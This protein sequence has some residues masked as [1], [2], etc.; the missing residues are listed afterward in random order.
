MSATAHPDTALFASSLFDGIPDGHRALVWTA[1]DKR[2]HWCDGPDAISDAAVA[3]AG[4]ADVYI[5]AGLRR[6]GHGPHVRGAYEDITG[7]VG[8]WADLDYAH[9]VHK[10]KVLPPD[11]D[12]VLGLLAEL[13]LAPTFIVHSGH[14]LQAWWG[15]AEPYMFE[16]AADR[17]RT[18]ALV[19]GWHQRITA[20]GRAHGWAID[21]VWDLPRILRLPG[22]FNRKS[23][24]YRP[25]ELVGPFGPVYAGPSDFADH[26]VPVPVP[27]RPRAA[28]GGRTFSD[29][30]TVAGITYDP[31]AEPPADRLTALATNDKKFQGSWDR[32]RRDFTDRSP[33]AYDQSLASIAA[34]AGWSD[35]EIVNLLIAARRKHGDDLKRPDYYQRT[36]ERARSGTAE[37]D[38]VATADLADLATED[39]DKQ[40]AIL[41]AVFGARLTRVIRRGARNAGLVYVLEFAGA[42]EDSPP[43]AVTLQAEGVRSI[44][45]LRAV[46]DAIFAN[47]DRVMSDYAR[48]RWRGLVQVIANCAEEDLF[49][50]AQRAAEVWEWVRSYVKERDKGESVASV[51]AAFLGDEP[52]VYDGRVSIHILHLRSYIVTAFHDIVPA[53]ELRLRLRESGFTGGP[54]TMRIDDRVV[55]RYRWTADA[56][57]LETE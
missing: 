35:Q 33:S 12:A 13:P 10:G 43:I 45:S 54:V 37:A 26:V 22:T 36:I 48:A 40:L 6:A 25:V 53:A 46:Q 24:P 16:D 31:A 23:A 3:L 7:I 42:D 20:A 32:T 5:G 52:Y 11:V 17:A 27:E 4:A 38:L 56:A 41:S 49:D 50:D 57:R 18:A 2:S 29:V 47:L 9:P 15:F 8:L 19:R 44:Q 55:T 39:R 14:G 1:P 51:R 28:G 34:R 30:Q 21:S